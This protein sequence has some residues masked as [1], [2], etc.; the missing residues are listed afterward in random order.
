MTTVKRVVVLATQARGGILSVVRA[1]SEAGLYERWPAEILWTHREG[2][3][4]AR[5][6]TAARALGRFVS[7]L[8]RGRVCLVHAHAAMYGSIW[9]KGL[10]IALARL[11][12]VPVVLHLHGSEFEVF[13][14]RLGPLGKRLVAAIFDASARVVVLSES[15]R[16]YVSGITRAEVTVVHN[17]VPTPEPNA[18]AARDGLLFLGAL[19]PR[20]GIYDLLEAV[21]QAARTI[22]DIRLCC[23]GNGDEAGVRE[24]VAQLGLERNV[25]VLGWVAGER[26]TELMRRCAVFVL[27]SYNEGLPMSIIEAMAEGMGVIA[28]DVGGIPELVESGVSGILVRPGEIAALSEAIVAMLQDDERR[29]A[30][31]AEGLRRFRKEY[32]R[33]HVI[34]QL[35]RIYAELANAGT[36]GSAP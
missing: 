1:H 9:R 21:A 10:F 2:S 31:A 6:A 29:R 20:K 15:W 25:E 32:S 5:L 14:G 23:A 7:L 24:R 33:E 17:F 36:L 35:D 28:S 3:L 18:D 22:P 8:L 16:R 11:F 26:K 12:R 19:G 4:G 27:P 34:P 30:Y 13:H